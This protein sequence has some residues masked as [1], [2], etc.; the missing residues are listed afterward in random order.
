[1]PK[2]CSEDCRIP[3][4][5]ELCSPYTPL[6]L[7]KMIVNGVQFRILPFFLKGIKG[8]IAWVGYGT[9]GTHGQHVTVQQHPGTC[10]QNTKGTE[11][12]SCV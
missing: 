6:V 9:V 1:M 5:Q 3:A 7:Y 4:I 8:V 11:Y 2:I 12:S 10:F